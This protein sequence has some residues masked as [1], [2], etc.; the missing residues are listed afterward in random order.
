MVDCIN[1]SCSEKVTILVQRETIMKIY[2]SNCNIS[3]VQV[4]VEFSYRDSI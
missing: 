4:Y 2:K 3:K 1:Y